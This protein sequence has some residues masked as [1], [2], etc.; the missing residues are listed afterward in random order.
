MVGLSRDKR[1]GIFGSVPDV[2]ADALKEKTARQI[3]TGMSGLRVGIWTRCLPNADR[4]GHWTACFYLGGEVLLHLAPNFEVF[5]STTEHWTV[6]SDRTKN[7]FLGT[8]WP[9]ILPSRVAEAMTWQN[10]FRGK[11]ECIGDL[12]LQLWHSLYVRITYPCEERLTNNKLSNVT[13][14]GWM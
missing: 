5:Y 12:Q 4:Y 11:R 14:N 13:H 7:L 8:A 6:L 3:S 10:T 1:E 9:N 2:E